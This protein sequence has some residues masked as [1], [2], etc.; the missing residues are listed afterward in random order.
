MLH[1]LFVIQFSLNLL[2]NLNP[3]T[4]SNKRREI[5]ATPELLKTI[6]LIRKDFNIGSDSKAIEK[7]LDLYVD[8]L[9]PLEVE[10]EQLTGSYANLYRQY[11]HNKDIVSSFNDSLKEF[12]KISKSKVPE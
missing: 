5:Q 9:L 11:K 6:A 4:M 2:S 7:A 10:F 12:T 8:Q 3:Y 1:Q